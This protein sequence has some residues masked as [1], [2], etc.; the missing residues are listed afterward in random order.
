MDSVWF[1]GVPDRATVSAGW[2]AVADGSVAREV[3]HEWSV[4]W[5][6]GDERASDPLIQMAMYHFHGF[7]MVGVDARRP[8]K[9]SG[10]PES[11]YRS[12]IDIEADH[13]WWR[14]EYDDF[15]KDP[16]AWRVRRTAASRAAIAAERQRLAAETDPATNLRRSPARLPSR[17]SRDR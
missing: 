7:D 17:S 5:V 3:A 14:T 16:A 15:D 2:A 10:P 9:Q 1:E 12:L 13:D 4:R 8:T 11:Y 6:E